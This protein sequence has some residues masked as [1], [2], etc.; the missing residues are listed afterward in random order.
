[1]NLYCKYVR[2]SRELTNKL[3][4]LVLFLIR[5]PS[6][7]NSSVNEIGERYSQF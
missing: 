4:Y 6:S 2:L 7:R 1:L 3:T 5:E